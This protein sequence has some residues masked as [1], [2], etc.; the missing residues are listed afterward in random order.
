[1]N[2]EQLDYVVFKLWRALSSMP[3]PSAPQPNLFNIQNNLQN[4][5]PQMP[6]PQVSSD[7]FKNLNLLALAQATNPIPQTSDFHSDAY[8]L[9]GNL[10]SPFTVGSSSTS[11]SSPH[12]PSFA[13]FDGFS[14]MNQSPQSPQKDVYP[15]IQ[16]ENLINDYLSS[17]SIPPSSQFSPM[18][19]SSGFQMSGTIEKQNHSNFT[20]DI[21]CLPTINS[22]DSPSFSS[23]SE[24]STKCSPVL[25]PR[26][27]SPIASQQTLHLAAPLSESSV[28]S[29]S[30]MKSPSGIKNGNPQQ[31]PITSSSAE[32]S[33]VSDSTKNPETSEIR[34]RCDNEFL[35]SLPPQLALK[36]RRA[37][38]AKQTAIIEELMRS[39]TN[40]A[41]GSNQPNSQFEIQLE[42]VKRHRNTDAARRSRLRKALRMET[43]EKQVISLEVENQKLRD[44]TAIHEKE[45]FE[46]SRREEELKEQ[47]SKMT[48]L[49]GSSSQPQTPEICN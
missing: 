10:V 49:L 20:N 12:T 37:R 45:K 14:N 33:P 48:E 21:G 39:T 47:I 23:S 27:S 29:T 22:F 17:Q 18:E 24:T 41:N 4:L 7:M 44:I 13:D 3:N 31:K 36:R 16:I 9:N 11:G 34:K 1:M 8:S 25:K 28:V 5:M 42:T 6:T 40:G 19:I 30:S 32:S 46:F 35:A 38:S 15:D 26:E 43:L 2:Q